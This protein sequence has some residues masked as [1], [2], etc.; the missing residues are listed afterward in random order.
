MKK[1]GLSLIVIFAV[2]FVLLELTIFVSAENETISTI[3]CYS[4]K[5]CSITSQY[6][7]DGSSAC[8]KLAQC[9]KR[10]LVENKCFL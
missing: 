8:Q 2:F 10:C 6:W 4:S 9:L 3:K 7:C 1:R 5:D